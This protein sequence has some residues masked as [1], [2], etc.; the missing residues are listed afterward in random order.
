MYSDYNQVLNAD[1]SVFGVGEAI[2]E[3]LGIV[4]EIKTRGRGEEPPQEDLRG[5]V[6]AALRR[7]ED[8]QTLR[9]RVYE[10]YLKAEDSGRTDE[11]A[12]CNRI[13]DEWANLMEE[14]QR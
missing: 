2:V 14:T 5:E 9:K 7:G 11:S 1:G 4:D 6:V 12:R 8:P 3:V 13:L 10:A